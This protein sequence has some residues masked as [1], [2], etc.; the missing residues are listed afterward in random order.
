MGV[1]QKY[2]KNRQSPAGKTKKLLF[3]YI[4]IIIAFT[5]FTVIMTLNALS[6]SSFMSISFS[7]LVVSVFIYCIFALYAVLSL[8]VRKIEEKLELKEAKRSVKSVAADD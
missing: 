6:D 2:R 3:R 5:L 8:R 4:K 7:L 1:I